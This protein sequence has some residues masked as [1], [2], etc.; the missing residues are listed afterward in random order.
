MVAWQRM[1]PCLPVVL[2]MLL[3]V[4]VG[5]KQLSAQQQQLVNGG[6]VGLI[7]DSAESSDAEL[8]S[9]LVVALNDGYRLRVLPVLGQGS[10]RNVE[11]LL[12]LRGIDVALVQ[13]DVLDFYRQTGSIADLGER[14]RYIAK[15]ANEEV[16]VLARREIGS[17]QDLERHRVN[18]GVEGSGSFL[19][20]G[21]LFNRLD[22]D[23]D[24]TSFPL[25][26][27]LKEIAEGTIDALIVVGAA[28]IEHLRLLDGEDGLHLLPIA[29]VGLGDSYQPA[30]IGAKD[31]PDL[32]APGV[33]VET[34]AVAKILTAFNWPEGHPR[35][36]K[37]DRFV[38]SLFSNIDRLAR[39]PFHPKWREVDLLSPLP[40]WQRLSVAETLVV[41]RQ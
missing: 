38:D 15:L 19:T 1:T 28:P 30:E 23:V 16:H 4:L 2:A 11:D 10:V 21:I 40:G 37:V 26:K 25:P 13:A 35:G 18:F 14:I 34:V 22:I 32:L 29:G 27:A 20:A 24:V 31:Y 41:E 36:E 6:T 7:I 3:A 8:A 39:P 33:A 17:L 5:G 9:D 12:F